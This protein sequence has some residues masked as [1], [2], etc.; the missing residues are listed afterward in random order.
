M[1]AYGWVSRLGAGR[2]TR[3]GTY[4]IEDAD[5]LVVVKVGVQVVDANRVDAEDLH[6]R[7]VTAARLGLAEGVVA[8]GGVP[9]GAAGL[10]VHADNLEAVAGVRVDEVPALDLEGR[11]GGG[12]GRRDGE[13]GG[14]E[15]RLCVSGG[16]ILMCRG[17][18]KG[19][20][21]IP[22]KRLVA[23]GKSKGACP[24]RNATQR[25]KQSTTSLPKVHRGSQ[26]REW[27]AQKR[28]RCS[29]Y[30]HSDDQVGLCFGKRKITMLSD[31][32]VGCKNRESRCPE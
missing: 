15:L 29:T 16:S 2:L 21:L 22:A 32:S 30:T 27:Q 28:L 5:A 10:V 23:S 24:Q 7:G 26:Q 1:P 8:V 9:R 3:R 4:S 17:P 13:Q 25:A 19:A 18:G 31:V 6:E 12:Q 20:E 11:D 14:G